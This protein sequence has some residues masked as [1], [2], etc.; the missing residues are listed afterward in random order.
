[1]RPSRLM[2]TLDSTSQFF[3]VVLLDGDANESISGRSFRESWKIEKL[4][5]FLIFWEKDHCKL[6]YYADLARAK[7]LVYEAENV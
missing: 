5:D 7:T 4:I 2:R 1:M 6:C 3:N